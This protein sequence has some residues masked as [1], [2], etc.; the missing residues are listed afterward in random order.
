[1]VVTLLFL[2][3]SLPETEGSPLYRY[4]FLFLLKNP[5]ALQDDFWRLFLNLSTTGFSC[6][7]QI[8][9]AMM[10]GKNPQ[11]VFLCL[12]EYP[13]KYEGMT[14]KVNTTMNY[15]LLFSFLA[16]LVAGIR[17]KIYR[18]QEDQKDQVQALSVAAPVDNIHILMNFTT[19][20]ISLLLLIVSSV[21][22]AMVNKM[23]PVF[24]DTYPNFLYVYVIHHYSPQSVLFFTALIYLVKNPQLRN[25]ITTEL[26]AKIRKW[27]SRLLRMEP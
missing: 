11:N 22:P 18:N 12:G 8:V 15:L 23:E 10:P 14:V 25:F 4:V 20:L 6:C 1:M 7:C 27:I 26:G 24:L 13:T 16:H 17:I 5:T 21:G 2:K 3:I 9:Y 19:N